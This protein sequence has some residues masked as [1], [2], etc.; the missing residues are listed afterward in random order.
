MPG[1]AGGCRGSV[2]STAYINEAR[3]TATSPV[4]LSGRRGAPTGYWR[5]GP[6]GYL[7]IFLMFLT[8]YDKCNSV[9]TFL[10]IN[11]YKQ[12][13]QKIFR[14]ISYMY[15]MLRLSFRPHHKVR[16]HTSPPAGAGCAAES[17]GKQSA[18]GVCPWDAGRG[19]LWEYRLG[20]GMSS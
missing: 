6:R 18:A 13:N 20:G 4:G 3:P 15:V 5:R 2:P 10:L 8:K 17:R 1:R 12:Y 11:P 14:V 16:T 9:E 19:R 7:V